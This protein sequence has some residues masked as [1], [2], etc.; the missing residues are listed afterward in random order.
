ML[1]ETLVLGAFVVGLAVAA[2]VLTF[3]VLVG[4]S[5]DPLPLYVLGG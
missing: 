3:F 5:R 1:G 2:A 4:A